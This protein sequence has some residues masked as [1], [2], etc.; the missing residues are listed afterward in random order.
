MI[1]RMRIPFWIAVRRDRREHA[2]EDWQARVLALGV[3]RVGGDAL[4][5]KV[6]AA[7]EQVRAIEQELGDL[8]HIE[9]VVE[10]RRS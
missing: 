6:L 9:P 7:P 5:L 2:P 1:R 10:H 4:R 8:V 3:E